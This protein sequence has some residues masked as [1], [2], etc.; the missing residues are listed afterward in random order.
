MPPDHLTMDKMCGL[1]INDHQLFFPQAYGS[2]VNYC[3]SL[4]LSV[5]YLSDQSHIAGIWDKAYSFRLMERDV[6]NKSY[7]K[8]DWDLRVLHWLPSNFYLNLT[9]TTAKILAL[10]TDVEQKYGEK[11]MEEKIEWTYFFARQ[12]GNTVG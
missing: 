2:E 3:P 10:Y 7:W 4:D 1:K 5:D 12:R 8:Q 11:V 9:T 6:E